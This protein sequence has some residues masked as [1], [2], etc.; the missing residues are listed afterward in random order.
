MGYERAPRQ[1]RAI[2][3]RVRRKW[4][5]SLT[6]EERSGN[7]DQ[8]ARYRRIT[9]Y[10][11]RGSQAKA[12]APQ[13]PTAPDFTDIADF[14]ESIPP[15]QWLIDG[16]IQR[17]FLYGLTAQTNHGKTAL[18]A[19]MAL[20]IGNGLQF[21]GHECESGH[22]LYLCGEGAR[23]TSGCACE[24]PARWQACSPPKSAAAS[25]S[26]P[27]STACRPLSNLSATSPRKNPLAAVIVDT[28][29]RV[30]SA[31]PSENS[32]VDVKMQ[33]AGPAHDHGERGQ[34]QRDRALPSRQR[35]GPGT[36]SSPAAAVRF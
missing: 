1:W 23:T 16:I 30:F 12:G 11:E 19:L 21:G 8:F 14:I 13:I 29:M 7:S 32:N 22:V 5:R 35:R 26:C 28:S 9:A 6:D 17:G 3:Y 27:T 31:T 2:G 10:V 36:I 20:A 15:P 33:R 34:A 24:V 18:A 25:R 4:W